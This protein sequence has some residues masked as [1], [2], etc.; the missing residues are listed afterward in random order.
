MDKLNLDKK[1]L[2]KFSRTMFVALAI[3]GTILLL[4]Q[5]E[6]YIWFYAIGASLLLLGIFATSLLKPVYI[7]WMRLAYVLAWINTRLILSIIFYS[8]FTPIG[9]ILRLFRVDLLDRRID[10]YKESYW[11]PKEKKEFNPADYERQF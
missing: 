2:R 8:V 7:V 1:N 6:A 10:K 11:K 5:K 3:I 9:L 4:K